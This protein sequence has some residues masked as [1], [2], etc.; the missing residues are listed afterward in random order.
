MKK[1]SQ[2]GKHHL[3]PTIRFPPA[4]GDRPFITPVPPMLP[5]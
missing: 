1:A 3:R 4:P 2:N 5:K